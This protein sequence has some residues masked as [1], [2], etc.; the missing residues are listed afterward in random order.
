MKKVLSLVLAFAMILGSFGFV[1]AS[2]F[3]DVK[4]TEYYS[5]PVNVLSG[6]GVIAGFPDGTFKP[7]DNVT[8]AQMATMITAALGIP[9]KGSGATGFS[10]VPASHWASGY[11][12]YAVSVG[13]VAGYPDKT[14]KPENPV[15]YNE[16]L[17]MIVAALGYTAE[18]LPGQWPGAFVNKARGLG[19]LDTCSTT[20]NAAAPRQDIAC[21]LYDA[22]TQ[23]IG[24][25]DK[26][27]A[28]QE[29]IGANGV[30]GDDTMM[31][32]LGAT[33]YT[34]KDLNKGD[35][36]VVTG[37]EETVINIQNYIGAY[38]TAYANKDNEIIAVKE[39]KSE[40]VE[41]S[42]NKAKTKVGDY[43]IDSA[44]YLGAKGDKDTD[45]FKGFLNGE[46][47]SSIADL[48][49]KDL[50]GKTIKVAAKTSGTKIT[51]IY[52]VQVWDANAEFM[53][54]EDVQ[55]VI[56]DDHK[57]GTYALPED[58]SDE[59]DT[60][61]FA[62]VGVSALS[63]IKEDD[64]VTIYWNN[65]KEKEIKKIEVSNDTVEGVISEINKDDEAVIGKTAYAVSEN[66]AFKDDALTGL[67]DAETEATFFLNYA[68]EIHDFEEIDE[69]TSSYAVVLDTGSS[70]DSWDSSTPDLKVKLFLADGTT[71]DFS[72]DSDAKVKDAAN[73]EEAYPT[74]IKPGVLVKYTLDS[75][76]VVT[77]F[78]LESGNKAD[79]AI[80][81]KGIYDGKSFEDATVVF[82]YSGDTAAGHKDWTDA[83]KYEVIKSEDIY[84][85]TVASLSF[86][87]SS[88]AVKA[89]LV[90]GVSGETKEYAIFIEQTGT[91]A[92]NKVVYTA[93]YEGKV[94]SL[95]LT[96]TAGDKA[97]AATYSTAAAVDFKLLTFDADKNVK[98]VKDNSIAVKAPEKAE[99]FDEGKQV[100]T[101]FDKAKNVLKDAKQSFELADE[102]AIYIIEDDEWTAGG[103]ADITGKDFK[104]LYLY[105]TSDKAD[106]VYDVIIVVK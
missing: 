102:V 69:S 49:A 104:A 30:K 94:Q 17:T 18:A 58:D 87:E 10:D 71:K 47:N 76:N 52:S 29:N 12:A 79:A 56:T 64:V 34:P 72:V 103:T 43:K 15:S 60:K 40:F 46:V 106:K 33:G 59:I 45:T 51:K 95:T 54:D 65:D 2:D 85:S 25:V 27:G 5:E 1:F 9:V 101:T 74:G 50:E 63:D 100:K 57:I 61:A 96:K 73:K 67:M 90:T 66:K 97:K 93:L 68:G 37:D 75:D 88:G 31:A 55:E 99:L 98:D 32:R 42:L 21:F 105:D 4:D 48:T 89:A 14:F 70:K 35:A 13:F 23:S 6:L 16:A 19:I 84:D 53:A 24:Y 62:L 82:S 91:K 44:T 41:E 83:G 8:R 28:F 38:I 81:A 22:L 20:G 11:I 77:A 39:V 92:G 80:S 36:F 7:G 86:I 26:D 78:K 3:S